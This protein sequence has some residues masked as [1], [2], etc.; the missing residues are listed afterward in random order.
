M[1]ILY[2]I[3]SYLLGF[4]LFWGSVS[5][6]QIPTLLLN[7]LNLLNL[8]SFNALS[9]AHAI[10]NLEKEIRKRRIDEVHLNLTKASISSDITDYLINL[11]SFTLLEYVNFKIISTEFK[12][13]ISKK[14]AS[15]KK[16][17]AVCLFSGGIDSYSGILNSRKYFNRLEGV[18]SA[19]SDQKKIIKIV[20]NLFD[21][22]LSYY[23]IDL[24]KLKAPSMGKGGYSQTRGFFYMLSTAA[25]MNLVGADNLIVS[26]C[27][28]T[29]Y[30]PQFSPADSVTL[31]SHPTIIEITKNIIFSILNKKINII[32]PFEDLTKA[33]IMSVYP[34]KSGFKLTHSCIKQRFGDHCGTCYGCVI[35]RSAGIASGIKDVQY[36]KD[37]IMDENANL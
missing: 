18:F 37:P 21:S 34:D 16:Y 15:K 25:H 30:Q 28:P 8:R 17:N 14:E 10:F 13:K 12:I 4:L 20:K 6:E 27:G 2:F 22:N 35:R 9:M 5:I 19:H 33:E 36:K 1:Q 3:S 26:E 11:I 7:T 24:F 32:T 29:M 31:T 23:G